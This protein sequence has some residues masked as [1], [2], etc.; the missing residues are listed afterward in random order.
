[1]TFDESFAEA[2]RLNLRMLGTPEDTRAS[3][4]LKD[5]E[6]ERLR[7][8]LLR[9]YNA[10]AAC[11]AMPNDC[12]EAEHVAALSEHDAVHALLAVELGPNVADER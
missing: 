4:D 9:Q 12:T 1:M 6:I 3:L 11:Y 2:K 8:L 10:D 7:A 5:A